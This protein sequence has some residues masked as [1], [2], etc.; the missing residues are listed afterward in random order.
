MQY[1]S[2]KLSDLKVV[3]FNKLQKIYPPAEAKQF[4]NLLILNKLGLSRTDQALQ[5]DYRISES[6]M[7]WFHQAVKQL[8]QEKPLQY[9]LGH[10]TFYGLP[11]EV[12]EAV[13]IPRPETEELIELILKENKQKAPRIIDLGTGSGCIA[14]ALKKNL[15]QA[16]VKG[17]DISQEALQVAQ[18]NAKALSLEVD[19]SLC[20]L[21]DAKSCIRGEYDIMVSNPPYVTESDRKSMQKNV[22]DYE[23][24][25]ALFVTNVDPL[26]FYRPIAHLALKH[27]RQHGKL[28]VEINEKYGTNCAELF[29]QKGLKDVQI[30]QDI[31]GK[32][33]FVSASKP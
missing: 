15:P 7:V 9:I 30:H 16:K 11:L 8:L 29:H 32:Q 12:N 20:N 27:L 4:I 25:L 5:I 6:E 3:W 31:H 17:I 24:G 10:T 13:L 2:N 1:P 26:Q 33:R 18:N 14:L 28:Y 21:L 22:L 23:P 19:F